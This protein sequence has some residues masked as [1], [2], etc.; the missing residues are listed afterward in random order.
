MWENTN[1]KQFWAV[2]A[3]L[4]TGIRVLSSSDKHNVI[5]M[6]RNSRYSQEMGEMAGQGNNPYSHQIHMEF[7]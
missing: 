4:M 3:T 6:R 2:E 7:L 5:G 1:S